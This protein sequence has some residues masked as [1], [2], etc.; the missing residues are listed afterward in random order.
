D[1][2]GEGATV[3][4]EVPLDE[5]RGLHYRGPF[6]FV[7]PGSA[8]DR[9]GD[10]R[11]WRYV[12]VADFVTTDEGTGIVH[13]APAFGEDDMR[14]ARDHDL[15]VVNPVDLEGRFD[16]RVGPFAGVFVKD[17]D[18]AITAD[19]RGRG[20]LRKAGEYSHTY[21]FCWRCGTPLLYYAKPSWYIA[22]TRKRERLLEV[23][24]E[25]DWH[26][27][28]IRDGRYGNWLANNVDWAL[29]RERYWGTPLPLWRC[30]GCEHVTAIGSLAELGE[31]AGRDLSDL[32][33]H[34]PFVDEVTFACECCDGTKRRVPGHID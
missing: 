19:L 28:H 2:L 31:R 3:L 26:P 4:R 14:V 6:D 5:L 13:L 7:G 30:D 12:T 16:A 23:N 33:P 25:V 29:S 17:A 15:P 8:D 27:E 1:V 9:G 24:A 20:L 10:P 34:R 18:A 11:A 21:P 32:D 22:T